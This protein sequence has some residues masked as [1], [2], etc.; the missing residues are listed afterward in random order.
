MPVTVVVGAQYGSEGKGKVAYEFARR[1]GARVAIRVG[2]SNSGHTVVAP[3]GA[4]H[5]FR[6]LPVASLISGVM[7]VIGPGSYLD[8]AVLLDEISKYGLSCDRLMIDANAV[9]I[10]DS[11]RE[12]E[13]KLQLQERYGST[14][15]GTGAAVRDRVLREKSLV[16]AKD[17]AVLAPFVK[18]TSSFLRTSLKKG[19]RILLEGT[20]GFGL[21]LLHSSAFPYVTSRDTTAAGFVSEAGLSP[22]DVDEIVLV[23]RSFPIRVAGNSGP[24][25]HETSWKAISECAKSAVEFEE[26]TS[27]TG[28]LRRVASFDPELVKAAIRV[29]APTKVVLNHLDYVDALCRNETALTK[30]AAEFLM[31]VEEQIGM[32]VQFFG[33]GEAVMCEKNIVQL[34]RHS[35]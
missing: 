10:G 20:Q 30:K 33:T 23:A 21:S 16:F 29:N 26:Y 13:A 5:V 2:G 17:V 19:E 14:L 15:S 25:P 34:A 8:L 3:N 27:V 18:H 4:R 7:S 24:L 32:S 1:Q 12:S 22:V 31:M 6:Q 28:R 11:H 9:I 35:S